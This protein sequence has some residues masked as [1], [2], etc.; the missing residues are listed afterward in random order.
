MRQVLTKALTEP[1]AHTLSRL[2]RIKVV[3]AE[4][5]I[6]M[7]FSVTAL[8]FLLFPALA[9]GVGPAD[10]V[11]VSSMEEAESL[12]PH[13]GMIESISYDMG[14]MV[15]SDK[16]LLLAEK[17]KYFDK[18]DNLVS[19]DR[20]VVGTWIG[21]Y[22]DD[23]GKVKSMYLV[24]TPEGAVAEN[25]SSAPEAVSPGSSGDGGEIYQEDG[26]YKN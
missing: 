8:V 11:T 7:L 9:F 15:I 20:F 21:V 22:L 13:K 4:K 6:R 23:Q 1:A 14:E 12:F 17:I 18:N 19:G 5:Y 25:D 10:V 24:D 26:V 2:W 3:K 16:H